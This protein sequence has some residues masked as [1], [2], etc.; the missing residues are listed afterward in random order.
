MNEFYDF[1][2]IVFLVEETKK[3]RMNNF[4]ALIT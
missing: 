4:W 1:I 2:S 3:I